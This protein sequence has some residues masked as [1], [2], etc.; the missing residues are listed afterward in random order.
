MATRAGTASGNDS[1]AF[2][3]GR[4]TMRGALAAGGLDRADL[5]LAFC[6][7]GSD[8]ALFLAGIRDVVGTDTPVIGGSAPG[9]ITHDRLSYKGAPAAVAAIAS[10]RIRFAVGAAGDL[11]GD[12]EATGRR[13]AAML[14]ADAAARLLLLFYDSIRAPAGPATP[15]VLNSSAPLLAGLAARLAPG[16]PM[17]GAGLLADF[18]FGRAW[19]F[20]GRG[21]V[22]RQA[23]GCLLSGDC[24]VDYVIMHGCIPAD[25]IYRRISRMDGAVIHELDGRPLTELLDEAFGNTDWR[26][27]RPVISSLTLALD[28]GPR[29]GPPRE[30]YF[31]GRLLTGV[32]PDG[33]GVGMFEADLAVG[34]E[35]RFMVRDNRLMQQS[36][37]ENT[38]RLLERARAAGREPFLALYIDCG[39]RSAMFSLTEQEEAAEVQRV[40]REAGVPLLGFYSGV[41][42]APLAGRSRGLDWTGVLVLLSEEVR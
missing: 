9:I 37:R 38:P 7:S 35:V 8:A 6:S 41:E 17:I 36:V 40:L 34:Q 24:A 1:D 16:V 25:G 4:E 13:L 29:Y 2:R 14:P 12:E 39:G 21:I 30:E 5:V 18:E 20:D 11:D 31:A 33:N 26:Q 42:I 10:D 15:P 23:V 3:L 22:D 28:C 27:E 19:Q 32:T